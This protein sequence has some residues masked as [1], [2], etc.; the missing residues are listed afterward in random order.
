M[1]VKFTTALYSI[2]IG[3]AVWRSPKRKA[4]GRDFKRLE[5]HFFVFRKY[6]VAGDEMISANEIV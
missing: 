1:V 2:V 4:N 6:L 5:S 3:Y